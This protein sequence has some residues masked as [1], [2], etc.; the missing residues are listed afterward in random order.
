MTEPKKTKNKKQISGGNNHGKN[1]NLR[2]LR[3]KKGRRLFH[4]R[5]TVETICCPECEKRFRPEAKRAAI[6]IEIPATT[7]KKTTAPLD[8][9]KYRV[10]M[11]NRQ[12]H[13]AT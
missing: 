9:Y 7:V 2:I 5:G 6:G 4:K 8:F 10:I 11:E 1:Q 13:A 12:L 3:K